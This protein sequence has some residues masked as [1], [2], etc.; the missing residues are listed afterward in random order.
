MNPYQLVCWGNSLFRVFACGLAMLAWFLG[1]FDERSLFAIVASTDDGHKLLWLML[2]FGSIGLIDAVVNDWSHWLRHRFGF[3]HTR[4]YRHFGLCGLAF[5]YIAQ[6]FVSLLH[7]KSPGLTA[8]FIWNAVLIVAFAFIDAHQRSK[9][10][11]P[12][13]HVCN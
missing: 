6:I 8:Y 1:V 11:L 10:A 3:D 4:A 12:C 7:V 13:S 5:C 2:I 9:D